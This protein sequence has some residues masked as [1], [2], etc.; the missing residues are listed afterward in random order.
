MGRGEC[1]VDI[2]SS[3]REILKNAAASVA[4]HPI[5]I[6]RRVAVERSRGRYELPAASAA[7]LSISL[8][9]QGVAVAQENPQTESGGEAVEVVVT[10][11][12]IAT[13]SFTTPT[14]VTVISAED[15]EMSGK[16]HAHQ[17]QED[18]PA[19]IPNQ[20]N[21]MVSSPPGGST[22]NLRGLGSS[23]TLLLMDGRRL[24]PTS[25]EGTVD[26]NIVPMS[27]I[28]RIE[29]VT[30]GASAAYG[31][32]AVAGVVNLILDT[33]FEGLEAYG[34]FGMTEYGD[35]KERMG[36]LTYGTS[37]GDGRG[38]VVLSGSVYRIDAVSDQ[39][40]RPW[41]RHEWAQYANPLYVPGSNNGE[42]R[43]LV[44]PNTRHSRMTAGGVISEGPLA[45][46]Q[47]G[48]GG[49]PM[50]FNYGTY[51]GTVFMVG[52]DGSTFSP[53]G[54]LSPTL[55]RDS[56]F[57]HVKF[58]L[59]ERTT[60]WAEA[61]FTRSTQNTDVTPNYDSGSLTIQRD[62][63]FL[64]ESIRQQMFDLGITSFRMGRASYE[65]GFNIADSEYTIQRYAVGLKGRIGT[66]WR[67]DLYYQYSDN[68]YDYRIF[69]NRRE[70]RWRQAIDAV[71][72][73]VTNQIVCRSTLTSPGNGCVPANIFGPNAISDEAVAYLNGTTQLLQT[74]TQHD[75]AFNIDGALFRNWAGDVS[76]AIGG[77][78][79]RDETEGTSDPISLA[80][81]W[82]VLNPQPLHGE[83]SV[84]E[85]YVETLIPL[86]AEKR[87]AELAEI[88]LAG[89][90]TDYTLSGSVNTWKAGLNYT[91]NDSLRLRA[92]RSR[93]IR[94]PNI[95][96]LFQSRGANPNPVI[97]PL[98]NQN[99]A[100]I[101]STG[102]NPDLIPEEADTLTFG[103]VYSPGWLP[104]LQT[105]VDVYDIE[106]QGA[107]SVIGAQQV[108]DGCY[109]R[110]QTNL[111]AGVKRDPVTNAIT[112]VAAVRFNADVL[113][114]SGVDIEVAYH[115]A[116]SGRLNGNLS[117]RLLGTY[118]D[119]L[120]TTQ[121]GVKTDNA[122][123]VQGGVPHWRVNLNALYRNGPLKLNALFRWVQ[124]G[125]RDN[126][127]VEGIDINDNHI[128]SH[129][130]VNVGADYSLRDNLSVFLKVENL[131]DKDP[132]VTTN[133]VISPQT[134]TSP[135]YDV[136]GRRYA[137]GARMSF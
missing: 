42:P 120:A 82:R 2:R 46:I 131:F 49:T 9:S 43:I 64:P 62:N 31:S 81:Q 68:E 79:R 75:V 126:D 92:T 71:V 101:V 70:D 8:L 103:V 5:G 35:S 98:T 114:A 110:G 33:E 59:S 119:E 55:G 84:K 77:E 3:I 16:Y 104:G 15:L 65:L 28:N 91:I 40:S 107:I 21:Q 96:E 128:G 11:S 50:P 18:I 88:N 48:P 69:N 108:V 85:F 118:V 61:L 80:R 73:P 67:W 129:F 116:L 37:F 117:L 102:G 95:N 17:I 115:T 52:G 130:Y 58:D 51:V 132:P 100:T 109:L 122:G 66:G 99:V 112:E 76:V 133:G 111:C 123:E 72:D 44:V 13:S 94:A 97:D 78:Y 105:S 124:A 12:R 41:G 90:V 45:G 137:L 57:G 20:A 7:V 134:A 56:A 87:F 63:A 54:N 53:T 74:Q 106:V 22:M 121:N 136:L 47:F 26:V 86:L 30:G 6:E 14:P 83:Q 135:F 113:E 19:L 4:D 29:T 27:L 34:Q 25:P 125:V 10:G 32:D 36:S 24:A 89:R 127:Y 1:T 39:S 60:L 93:D 23:R 38:N